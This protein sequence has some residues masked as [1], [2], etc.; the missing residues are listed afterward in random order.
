MCEIRLCL[1]QRFFGLFAV[2]GIVV[3]F[4]DRGTRRSFATVLD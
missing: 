3:G 2:R 4:Q 1:A